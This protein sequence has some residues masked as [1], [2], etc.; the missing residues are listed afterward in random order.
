MDALLTVP[1]RA[2]MVTA[3]RA[4]NVRSGAVAY[5]KVRST[6]AV[7]IVSRDKNAAEHAVRALL[8]T[9]SIAAVIAA[10]QDPNVEAAVNVSAL[11][12]LIAA[13]GNPALQA[14]CV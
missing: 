4:S 5:Q 1:S 13:E 11:T 7:T 10:T 6:A 9:R 12:S 3:R 14:T 2:E 8:M